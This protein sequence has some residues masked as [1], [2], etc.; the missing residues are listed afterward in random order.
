M[1]DMRLVTQRAV[2][3]ARRGRWVRLDQ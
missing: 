2:S 3:A 1:V